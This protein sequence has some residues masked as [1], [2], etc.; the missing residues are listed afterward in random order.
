MSNTSLSRRVINAAV[1]MAVGATL[2]MIFQPSSSTAA[3]NVERTDH[4]FVPTTVAIEARDETPA[5]TF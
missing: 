3:R 4:I 1:F 5:P 2:A